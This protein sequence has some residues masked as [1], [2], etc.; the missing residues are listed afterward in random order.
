MDFYIG[1]QLGKGGDAKGLTKYD[2]TMISAQNHPFKK[3]TALINR[4]KYTHEK[5]NSYHY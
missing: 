2:N 4:R 1:F 5:K 3:R